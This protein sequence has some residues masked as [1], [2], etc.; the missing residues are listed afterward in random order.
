MGYDKKKQFKLT[1][2]EFLAKLDVLNWLRYATIVKELTNQKPQSVLEAGPGEGVIKKVIE[3]FVEK[4]D[5]L[6]INPKLSP[7]YQG[8]IRDLKNELRGKYDCVIAADILEHIPFGDL[9]KVLKNF[10]SYLKPG[11]RVLITIPHRAWFL[12]GMSWLFNYKQFVIR[13][14]DWLR[15]FYHRLRRRKK[16]PIDLDHEW[17]VGDGYHKLKDVEEVMK[18]TGFKIEKRQKLIYVDFWTLKK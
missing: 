14:P 1:P 3:D 10:H 18:K 8:D 12:F 13:A 2:W 16:N 17:E 7:T 4:Y 5:T 9:E 15:T 6:D 11:G